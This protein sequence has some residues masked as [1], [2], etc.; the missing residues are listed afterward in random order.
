[1]LFFKSSDGSLFSRVGVCILDFAS[2]SVLIIPLR[3][4]EHLVAMEF[5]IPTWLWFPQ[6]IPG[7]HYAQLNRE[8]RLK[9][10]ECIEE[11]YSSVDG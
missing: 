10:W 5:E 7:C 8:T 4:P 2:S 11:F 6:V 3:T 9:N 1:M